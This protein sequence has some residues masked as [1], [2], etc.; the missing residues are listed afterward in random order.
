MMYGFPEGLAYAA[1]VLRRR[2]RQGFGMSMP[3]AQKEEPI[4]VRIINLSLFRFSVR[5]VRISGANVGGSRSRSEFD[6]YLVPRQTAEQLSS[7]FGVPRPEL[8]MSFEN[9]QHFG[10]HQELLSGLA[11]IVREARWRCPQALQPG[12]SCQMMVS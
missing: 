7:G 9:V 10:L 12:S 11:D 1:D 2:K 8:L 5:S 4:P 6:C 3:V